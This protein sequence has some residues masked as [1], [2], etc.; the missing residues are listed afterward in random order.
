MGH[1]IAVEGAHATVCVEP[2]ESCRKC[3]AGKFCQAAGTRRL[4]V[5]ENSIG[6]RVDDEVRVEQA[7]AVGLSAAFLLFGL[8]VILAVIGL[9]AAR[10]CP[11]TV[12][13][14][15][16]IAGFGSGL[17]VAKIIN[18]RLK[19]SNFLPRIA[20]IIGHKSP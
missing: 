4:V 14:I 16:G 1:V 17:L 11:E 19:K 2:N 18:D 6:A 20:G 7:A 15:A 8:P 13:L 3:D 10:R 5:A 9:L 12:I